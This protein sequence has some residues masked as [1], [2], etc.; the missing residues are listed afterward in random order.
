MRQFTILSAVAACI[1]IMSTCAS[2]QSVGIYV[3]P[4]YAYGPYYGEDYYT[5]YF[6]QYGYGYY[7]GHEYSYGNYY[8]ERRDSRFSGYR[9]WA[10]RAFKN[11]IN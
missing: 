8:S 9:Y 6:P 1:G 2:A 11:G 5:Y 10:Q 3:G 4:P 7:S